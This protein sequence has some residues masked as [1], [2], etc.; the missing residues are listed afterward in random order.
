MSQLSKI[1]IYEIAK[2]FE[3]DNKE[4]INIAKKLGINVASHLSSI[5]ETDAK[6]IKEN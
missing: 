4:V 2:E 5:D 6:K 3:V 1:K